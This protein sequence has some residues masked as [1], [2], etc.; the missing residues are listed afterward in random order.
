[1][2]LHLLGKKSWN[3]YNTDN[4]ARVRRDEAQAKAEEEAEEQRMQEQDSERRLAILR[5][6]IPPPL[7]PSSSVDDESKMLKSHHDDKHRERRPGDGHERRKRK[8]AGEND[9]DFEMRLALERSN[10]SYDQQQL[11][12]MTKNSSSSTAEIVDSRGHISLFA[13]PPAEK[14]EEAEREAA[15][16]KQ[17]FKDQYQMRFSHAAGKDVDSS[18]GPWYASGEGELV[19]PGLPAKNVFGKD[20]PNRQAREAARL[21]SSDP[22]AMMKRG[23]GKVRELE[24]FRKRE[25]EERERALKELKREEK[26]RR[27]E[28]RER[29]G[30]RSRSGEQDRERNPDLRGGV[31]MTRKGIETGTGTGADPETDIAV[32]KRRADIREGERRRRGLIAA[33]PAGRKTATEESGRQHRRNDKPSVADTE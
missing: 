27:R 28:E 4:I 13:P 14:N 22:L 17:E 26:R 32:I 3:V 5:G 23:A 21:D 20:D 19:T 18:K 1:M 7:P 2:P 11:L 30:G 9:T 29:R 24:Q 33:I 16:K 31:E 6:E 12:P 25:I 8:R 10:Q 15:A